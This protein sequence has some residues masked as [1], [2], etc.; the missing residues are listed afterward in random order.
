MKQQMVF[1]HGLIGLAPLKNRMSLV[2]LLFN[3]VII[4]HKKTQLV[5][6]QSQTNSPTTP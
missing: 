4:E 6:N 3:Y 2:F 5:L 1:F